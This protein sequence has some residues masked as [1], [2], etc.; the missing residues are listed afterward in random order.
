MTCAVDLWT[1]ALRACCPQGPQR[2]N[3]N[4]NVFLNQQWIHLRMGIHC[5]GKPDHL[6]PKVGYI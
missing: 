5:S 6:S 4:S 3:S 1:N 2:N